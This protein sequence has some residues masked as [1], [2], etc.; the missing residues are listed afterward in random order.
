MFALCI[1]DCCS[2]WCNRYSALPVAAR[3]TFA[4][5]QGCLCMNP[6]DLSEA[7]SRA[8]AECLRLCWGGSAVAVKT[9]G[10]EAGQTWRG[11]VAPACRRRLWPHLACQ[12]LQREFGRP[13]SKINVSNHM[14]P[15]P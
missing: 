7:G 5:G 3:L 8:H 1:H 6:T 14:Y 4:R 11:A 2:F 15:I 9:L 12:H 10:R 13:V